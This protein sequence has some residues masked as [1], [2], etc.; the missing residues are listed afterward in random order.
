MSGYDY[1]VAILGSGIA[2]STLANILARHGH[3]VVLID[4]GTHPRFALGESTIG[5]TTYL[6]KLLAQRFDVPELGH[7][8][9][10]EGVRSHVTSAC[11]VKRNFGFV[12]HH[13]GALQ[14]PEEVTQ[15]S[16]SEFPNGPEMHMHRQDIDA[17]LFY[18]AVRYGAEPRQRTMVE[19]VDFADD[20]ATLTTGAGE[21]IRVRY[22][23][24]ASGRN[25][26]L[27]NQFALREDPCRFRTNSRTLFT[28]MVGVTPFDEVTLPSGQPS[29]WHQGTLHHLFDG[30]WLWVIPFDNHQRATNPL[31]SV[32]L[33]L[34]SRRFPRDP[35][36]PAEQ[37]WNA[38]LE[39]FPSI[40][41]QFAGARPAWDWIS[42]GRT[43]YSSSRT[44]GDRWAMMSHA[45]GAIDALFSRGM[46]NTMQVIYALAPTL[47]E[48]LADDDFSAERFGH[49]DTLNQ[50]ILDVNDKLVHGSYVSFRDF[51]L[52]RAWSKVWFLGWNMGISRIVGTYFGYLEKGDPALFDRLLDAPHL[53]T[54]C[55]D[56][57]EFQPFFDSLSAVM[58]EVEAGRL[59]PAAAVERLATLLGGADFLPAPLRLGDVLRRWH[60]GSFEAQRRMYEWG[61]TSSP[62]PL[63]RWYEYDLDDLLTRTGG[64]PTPA[65][66]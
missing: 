43:Q 7:V 54:F 2:G 18:T 8:S 5:E 9:S 31:C 61:R 51:D 3:R 28:H 34:D 39:R 4:S 22:V 29:L 45:A 26:V 65:T 17:Y 6:L 15:C 35:S 20:A 42:T 63:R 64:V 27:A 48:A 13:E 58:D 16:V 12:Y 60:D 62:E 49:I 50:T 47:I 37:E 44:V 57:P 30:G 1:S 46:A 32:G 25:S 66:L 55:P 38:Y 24:D 53:G 11:G 14:N 19:K 10:F 40:A 59:A 23:V 36:V 41:R 56:L 52:W 33:N 21:R